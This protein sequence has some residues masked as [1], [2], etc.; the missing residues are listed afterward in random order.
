MKSRLAITALLVFTGAILQP[1]ARAADEPKAAAA[2]NP[3][4]TMRHVLD[5]QT[6][7]GGRVDRSSVDPGA[8]ADWLIGV[9]KEAKLEG[10]ADIQKQV[11]E[12]RPV[13]EKW[14]AD[15]RKAGGRE[16]YVLVNLS[17]LMG[18]M[19][20]VVLPVAPGGDAPRASHHVSVGQHH[21]FGLPRA[22]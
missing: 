13:A 5:D 9:A 11:G 14:L 4:A 1:T 6:G 19:P 17:D 7:I 20:V 8:I 3:A 12:F 22:P 2:T 18:G 10:E 15:F 16:L 21:A